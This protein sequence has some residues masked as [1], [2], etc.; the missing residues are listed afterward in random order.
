MSCLILNSMILYTDLRTSVVNSPGGFVVAE[1]TVSKLYIAELQ[2]PDADVILSRR[3][4]LPQSF[5]AFL[6]VSSTGLH[7]H[8]RCDQCQLDC[9]FVSVFTNASVSEPA[10]Q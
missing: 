10:P 7:L 5:Q 1:M 4:A 3:L 6:I 9:T 2:F 8:V